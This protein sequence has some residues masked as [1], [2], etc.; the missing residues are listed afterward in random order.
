MKCWLY[1]S[2]FMM[3]LIYGTTIIENN[4]TILA[5]VSI[6]VGSIC[7]FSPIDSENRRLDVSEKKRYRTYS[8][9]IALVHFVFYVVLSILSKNALAIMFATGIM[10][11]SVLQFIGLLEQYLS[12][13]YSHIREK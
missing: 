8:R 11:A 9:C 10:F 5:F 1:S 6:A 12:E 3:V 4:S 7:F 13:H 2:F